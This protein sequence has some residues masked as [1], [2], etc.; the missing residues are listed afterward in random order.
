MGRVLEEGTPH[1]TKRTR[2]AATRAFERF[3]NETAFGTRG[4]GLSDEELALFIVWCYQRE[5]VRSANTIESYIF[6]GAR[7]WHVNNSRPWVPLGQRPLA[8]RVWRAVQRVLAPT[9]GKRQARPMTV[10]IL[11]KMA[12]VARRD[13]AAEAV[14]AAQTVA[15]W[16]MFRIANITADG[17]EEPDIEKRG[18]SYVFTFADVRED[19][20]GRLSL[21]VRGS[22]TRTV[23]AGNRAYFQPLPII[24]GKAECP[25][26]ALRVHLARAG[27]ERQPTDQLFGW[28]TP[29]GAW[30]PLQHKTFERRL[31]ATLKAA[32]VETAG[33][34][35]HSFRRGGATFAFSHAKLDKLHIQLVGDWASDAVIGYCEADEAAR[36]KA[37]D[38][39]AA[40]A[41]GT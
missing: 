6:S 23:G 4:G 3:L 36:R 30:A 26:A 24:P 29:G 31:R 5:G 10:D 27:E 28:Q 13:A 19:G 21:H 25:T 32:G 35:G 33:Y 39:M 16:C 2:S 15:F 7:N 12:A 37:V 41:A 40:A 9:T 18:K 20:G 1:N 34:S 8:E 14:H 38:E 11:R 22:K 17:P